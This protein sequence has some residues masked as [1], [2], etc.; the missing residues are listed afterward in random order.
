MKG[1]V[2]SFWMGSARR[3]PVTLDRDIFEEAIH[4]PRFWLGARTYIMAK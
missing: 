4:A 2:K 3:S 1:G